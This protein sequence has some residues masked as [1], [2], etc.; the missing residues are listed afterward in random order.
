MSFFV[1]RNQ[2][3]ID[4]LSFFGKTEYF[5]RKFL[6]LTDRPPT[7]LKWTNMDIWLTTYPPPLVQVVFECPLT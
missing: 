3:L 7:H 5:H 6:A 4:Y 2:F 1:V